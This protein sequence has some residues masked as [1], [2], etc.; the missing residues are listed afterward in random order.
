MWLD[1]L[2]RAPEHLKS[3]I[4][5]RIVNPKA[6][7]DRSFQIINN[8]LSRCLVEHEK[9][10]RWDSQYEGGSLPTRVLDVGLDQDYIAL[11]EPANDS[12]E[13]YITL[14]HCWGTSLIATTT[15]A[16]L[17]QGRRSIP[18]S[19]LSST[20]RD[21][22]TITRRLGVRYLWIDALCIIQDDLDDWKREAAR[23]H[24]V[25]SQALVTVAAT[26]ARDGNGGCFRPRSCRHA[27]LVRLPWDPTVGDLAGRQGW[28]TEPLK[29]YVLPTIRSFEEE[30][31]NSPLA[32]RGWTFQ[33]RALAARTI[34]FGSELTFWECKEACIGEDNEMKTYS[35][36]DGF[37]NLKNMLVSQAPPNLPELHEQWAFVIES[38]S[39]R[40]L[41]KAIDKL[42]AL[43]GVAQ[44]FG[45]AAG[46]Y[47]CGL[48]E[49]DFHRHLLWHCDRSENLPSSR[50]CS[51]YR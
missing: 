40:A 3:L 26:A 29:L 14:S 27:E 18:I 51:I 43:S 22:V 16:S 17:E 49:N 12:K 7:S 46:R 38:Y 37:F 44:S 34:H 41:T 45:Q 30:I 4:N 48:W 6:D 47:I 31:N 28:P 50:R 23:M 8:W 24:K 10:G 13:K 19:E 25:Y 15:K 11:C 20:F 32:L 21:A 2:D 1:S 39:R 42:P 5:A 36:Q 9:C 35:V 33:E